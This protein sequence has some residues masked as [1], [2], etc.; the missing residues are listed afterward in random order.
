MERSPACATTCRRST[1]RFSETRLT[2]LTGTSQERKRV[3]SRKT[4]TCS[5]RQSRKQIYKTPCSSRTCQ[6]LYTSLPEKRGQADPPPRGHS[7]TLSLSLTSRS[8]N[9]SGA[10]STEGEQDSSRKL[11]QARGRN[12]LPKKGGFPCSPARVP[13]LS[14]VT[15][16]PTRN[17]HPHLGWSSFV[18]HLKEKKSVDLNRLRAAKVNS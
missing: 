14:S 8:Q 7:T 5:W 16:D 11:Y 10:C 15:P 4:R 18:K 2:L 17:D 1:S 3:Y 12:P 9:I 13:L 6:V